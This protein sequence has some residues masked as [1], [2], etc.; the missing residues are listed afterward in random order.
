MN[1]KLKW[2]TLVELIVVITIL[3]ILGTI[4]FVQMNGFASS[5]RDSRRVSDM[6][7]I[8]QS[9]ELAIVAHG[10]APIPSGAVSYTGGIVSI[11]VGKADSKSISRMS[12]D[13]SDPVTKEAYNYSI[14]ENGLYYQIGIDFENPLSYHIGIP[15]IETV[16]A[17]TGVKYS[18]LSGNYSFDPSLPS[19][20]PITETVNSNSGGIFSPDVCFIMENSSVNT[21]SSNSGTCTKKKDMSLKDLDSS[22]VGYWDME[23]Y[24]QTTYSGTNNVVFLKDLSGNWYDLYWRQNNTTLATGVYTDTGTTLFWTG[25]YKYAFFTVE[26][27]STIDGKNILAMPTDIYSNTNTRWFTFQSSIY[28]NRDVPDYTFDSFLVSIL[29]N[30]DNN[31]D[32]W[33]SLKRH[34]LQWM[35]LSNNLNNPYS[36]FSSIYHQNDTPKTAT[37]L[38]GKYTWCWDNNGQIVWPDDVCTTDGNLLN[39]EEWNIS[40]DVVSYRLFNIFDKTAAYLLTTVYDYGNKTMCQYINWIQWHC[41][42]ISQNALDRTF[43]PWYKKSQFSIN[44]RYN[45]TSNKFEVNWFLWNIDEIKIYNR[46]LSDKEIKQ[47]A[48]IAGF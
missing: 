11:Q 21:F 22:L 8:T 7:N 34:T 48:K 17:D 45:S 18:K 6:S 33:D 23:S 41:E 39:T 14:F 5:A 37:Y 25:I 42:S 1:N 24:Y 10:N 31:I 13:F 32:S 36:F 2:F 28:Y 9:I 40:N 4:G 16:Y 29:R 44:W 35:R 38:N 12:G 20:F 30:N 15:G 47:Q 27:N 3:S 19:L 43:E 46:T 26:N